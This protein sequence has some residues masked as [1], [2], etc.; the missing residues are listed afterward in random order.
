VL[1]SHAADSEAD[2]VYRGKFVRTQL[3]CQTI[4][5]RPEGVDD[6]VTMRQEEI[7][8]AASER[9]RISALTS[10]ADCAFCHR[11]MNGPGFAFG[12]YD[13]IGRFRVTDR[14]GAT[15][16]TAFA[17]EGDGAQESDVNGS[18]DSALE[19]ADALSGSADVAQC[20]TAQ[21]MRFALGRDT[22]A[23]GTSFDQAYE[24]FE[25]SSRDL[26]ELVVA[27]TMTDAFR[28]R[29]LPAGLAP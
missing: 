18:Y 6:A 28:Y 24:V 19:L 3:L 8:A 7:A 16:D 2:A 5:N 20:L 17:L 13:S 25:G 11:L 12:A 29:K 26:R 23:E 4:G 1:A 14:T 9:E 21:W 15:V 22:N 27:I 10:G